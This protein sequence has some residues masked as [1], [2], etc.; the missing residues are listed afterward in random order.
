MTKH[1]FMLSILLFLFLCSP[2]QATVAAEL[3]GKVVEVVDGETIVVSYGNHFATV[4]LYTVAAPK[5]EHPLA[6]V[7]RQHLADFVLGRTVSIRYARMESD[8]I[9]GLVFINGNDIGLQMVRDGAASY[10]SKHERELSE[11]TRQLYIESERAAR[12]EKLGIWRTDLPVSSA[13]TQGAEPRAVEVETGNDNEKTAAAENRLSQQ[14]I[15]LYQAGRYAEAVPLAQKVLAI[16]EKALGPEHPDVAQALNNL[17][18][19]YQAQGDYGRAAPLYQRSLAIREKALGPEHPQVAL[20][21]NNLASLYQDQG[22]YGRA[23]P[24]YQR[25]LAIR[26]KALGP[27]HRDVA[28]SLNNL[29]LLYQNQ[30][31]YGRAAPLYQRS[32][33]IYEK[34]L[35]PEHPSVALSLNNLAMLYKD[36]GDYGRAAPLY[37]RS[38]AIR[39]KA[40]GPEHP[41]VAQA[42]NNLA[43]LY[44][45]QGDYGRAAPLFQRALTIFEKALG[46]EHPHVATALSNL[47][48]LYLAQGDYGRAAPLFQR[49]LAICEKALGPEHPDV[50]TALSNL[51]T[52]YQDQ[53]DYG[54]AAPL[55]QR[56]LAI[57]E[58]ALGPE[59]PDVAASLNNLASLHEAQGD[60]ERAAPLFQRAL[61]IREK[62]L[63][64]EHPDVAASLNNLASLYQDQGD[65]GRAAPLYQRSLVIFEKA[66]GPE[67]PQ[68]A[69]SLSNL[70]S[71]H[72][73]QGD[74]ERALAFQQRASAVEEKNIAQILNTGSQQQKQLY[75]NTLSGQTDSTVSLHARDVPRNADAARLALTVILQR[76]GRALDATSDQIAA[77]RSRA[78]PD[79]QKL[80]DQ[81]TTIQS[82]L[83]TL[84]LSNTSKLSLDSRRAEIARLTAEQERLEDAISRRSAEF[85]AVA[86]PITLDGVRQAMP[87]DAALVELFVYRP[88]NAQAKTY[89]EKF[90]APRY[91][92]Y[93][94]RS[95]N[96]VPQ[97]VDLGE[98]ATI[99]A[100]AA[101][102]RAALQTAKT[103]ETQ[104]KELARNLDER[105]MRPVRKLLGATRRVFLS[106][107][108]ALNLVPFDAFVDE[109]GHYLIENYSFNYLTSGRDLLRPQVAG[110]SQDA[111]TIVANPLFDM[112]S[113]VA[114]PANGR[115]EI[116]LLGAG[117]TAN[118]EAGAT[119]FTKLYYPPLAGTAAEA[120][121]IG[122]LLPQARVWTQGDATEAAL[123]SVNRPSILHIATHGFFLSD[124]PQTAPAN[125]R[126]LVQLDAA[127]RGPQQE[128]PMLRSG[129]ILAGVKQKQSG[130]GEDGVL[131]AQEAAGLN[132]FGTKLVVLS[133]CETGLGDVENG[134]GVYGLRRALVLAGSET[135]VM[136][137]WRVSDTATRDLMIAYYTRLQAGAGRIAALHEVQLAMLR[138]MVVAKSGDAP[139]P[140]G[141]QLVQG[142]AADMPKADWR[143][144][145]YWAAFIPSGAWTTLDG[146]EPK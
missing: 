59:H 98:A 19:L 134:A 97:F 44:Q 63:G 2:Q 137:L 99:D 70:A 60:Y 69:L 112:K 129:L 26:E 47:G 83:A 89:A 43:V 61:A 58:K 62:A 45:A 114:A 141:R 96:D 4:R 94:L 111:P 67:H 138:G 40:L 104:V 132:L 130:P 126:Q 127:P 64:P 144:P 3:Q 77:L 7:I 86:Q 53:G 72:E 17:A 41:D 55:F 143:H 81:L 37:Q 50:A 105:V 46:L 10:N 101:K 106:P 38:L 102:F 116:G 122:A 29:A 76:K 133:A 20:S 117:E 12:N 125:A 131:T 140:Q 24:L 93:V 65:Y 84:Q 33:A 128:N 119:D 135:Q 32:L 6:E 42:L 52:L 78:A 91:V 82:Q 107:D 71:L 54:R 15:Q 34:A 27:E 49:A 124:Q 95:V 100:D 31:D 66:L 113:P 13:I 146:K 68:V 56:A 28:I 8:V 80:L 121:S 142:P 5:K 118:A 9:Y 39:E 25:S 75:L 16:R 36:Q 73:A 109:D 120:K 108:G 110:Q 103:P 22:D 74:Y 23:A 87:P 18:M 85:R 21:L 92:A 14:V 1:R 139:Q 145:Y 48:L 79:D 90:G 11:I 57:R 30:G 88:F 35:G 136:S 51:A 123:K 115:R